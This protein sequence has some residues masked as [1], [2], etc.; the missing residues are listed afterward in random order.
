[1]SLKDDALT[2]LLVKVVRD[3]LALLDDA[4][5]ERLKGLLAPGSRW[6]VH[7]ADED[8]DPVE[9][10]GVSR[11]KPKASLPAPKV[12]DPDA[13]LAW[14]W[15]VRPDEVDEPPPPAPRVR[16]AFERWVL[17]AV[18]GKHEHEPWCDPRT[19]EA[20]ECPPG[21]SWVTPAGA[22]S[23][24]Q[25]RSAEAGERVLLEAMRS[26]RLALPA[27]LDDPPALEP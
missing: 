3:R 26:G 4:A 2:V 14:T 10:G 17:E 13:F 25:V 12:T 22:S 19:G 6:V 8:G 16:P 24:L 15:L 9:V 23:T 7:V 11:T 20:L 21:V 1:M 5:R 27:V 18:A